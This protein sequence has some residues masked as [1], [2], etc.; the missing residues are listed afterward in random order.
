MASP[1]TAQEEV[2]LGRPEVEGGTLDSACSSD[3]DG[4]GHRT[5]VE[6]GV[7][8]SA[9]Y[10]GSRIYDRPKVIGREGDQVSSLERALD[11]AP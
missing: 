9:I 8:R 10:S 1:I 4:V 11:N 6:V 7:K 3:F 5:P 2:G